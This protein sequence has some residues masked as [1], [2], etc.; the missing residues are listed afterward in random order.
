[1][2]ELSFAVF[3]A[4]PEDSARQQTFQ[5]ASDLPAQGWTWSELS[6]SPY[7]RTDPTPY[8]RKFSLDFATGDA[9]FAPGIGA[10]QGA[11]FLFSDL[12]SDHLL[13][14]SVTSFQGNGLGGLI[15]NLNGSL[16][17]L[18]QK[19]RL[20]WG[21]GAFRIRGLFYENDFRTVYDETSFGTFAD[22]RWPFSRFSR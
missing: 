20:N 16:F 6:Q 3:R 10:A 22:L 7:A 5:L 12:L 17:Y 14:A 11:V 13:F 8:D 18:N 9:A 19:R 21:A 2:H 1:F 4:A 15:N